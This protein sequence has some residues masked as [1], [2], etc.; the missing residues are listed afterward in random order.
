MKKIKVLVE[1][2]ISRI[3]LSLAWMYGWWVFR[4]INRIEIIG[5]NNIPH[6]TNVLYVSNHQ[7]LIDSFLVGIGVFRFFDIFIYPSRVP[8]SAPDKENFFKK[9]LFR[10][11]FRF[12]NNIPVTRGRQGG[13]TMSEQ[14]KEFKNRLKQGKLH[15][16]FEGTRTR[17][18]SI[19][20]CKAGVAEII[21]ESRPLVVPILLENI[22][23]IMPIEIGFKFFRVRRG[24][25][26]VMKIGQPIKF[27]GILDEPKD[28][29]TR[30]KI[31]EIVRQAVLELQETKAP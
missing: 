23:P 22:Q 2:L 7:T 15:L 3:F 4:V 16:F 31:G 21:Y 25:K 1:S 11:V 18:G 24:V 30:K 12:L 8:W 20:E 14:L 10:F 5:K 9:R 19:G 26:G 28:S 13:T 29:K 6:R 27:N 17:D